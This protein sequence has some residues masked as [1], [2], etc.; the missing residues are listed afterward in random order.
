L[1]LVNA[2]VPTVTTGPPPLRAPAR[3]PFDFIEPGAEVRRQVVIAIEAIAIHSV[4]VE[5]T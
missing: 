4:V 1:I 3:T 2:G 5:P